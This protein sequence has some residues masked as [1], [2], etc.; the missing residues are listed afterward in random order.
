MR[1][2]YGIA[3]A[4]SATALV[5][6]FAL[7]AHASTTPSSYG[8]Q[9]VALINQARSQHGVPALTVTDGTSEVATSWTEQLAAARALSHNPN[10]QSDLESHGSPNW[11]SYAENVGNAS[12]SSATQ[13]FNAY[14]NSAE[15]RANILSSSFRYLGV[16]V[17]FTGSTAWN[18]LDFVDSYSWSTTSSHMSR[19]SVRTASAPRPAAPVV[20]VRT[21]HTAAV[22]PAGT[23]WESRT[24][25]PVRV[26]ATVKALHVSAPGRSVAAPVAPVAS[27]AAPQAL[28]VSPSPR[29][30]KRL[31]PALVAAVMIGLVGLGLL[32]SV[33][34]QREAIA[35]A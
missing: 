30:N 17:V 27:A 13:L 33:R 1:L 22:R 5:V 8:S 12:S 7:P 35:I 3:P 18:T 34:R 4:L 9:L 31:L 16:G 24:V 2:R 28:A 6:G 26:H 11:T 10:L 20:A 29:L 19:P 23:V 15:H 21:V 25:R 14:M 32:V